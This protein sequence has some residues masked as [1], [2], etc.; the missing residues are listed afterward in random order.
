[1]S[2]T[3]PISSTYLDTGLTDVLSGA[4][5]EYNGEIYFGMSKRGY[6]VNDSFIDSYFFHIKKIN[7]SSGEISDIGFFE[8]MNYVRNTSTLLVDDNY[9]YY[10]VNYGPYTRG[11]TICR[12]DLK[13]LD[14]KRFEI[15]DNL[16]PTSTPSNTYEQIQKIDWVDNDTIVI[17][18]TFGFYFFN[19]KTE[20]W[21]KKMQL[22]N[23][24]SRSYTTVGKNTIVS[25]WGDYRNLS[26]DNQYPTIYN[27]DTETFG[28]IKLPS[29]NPQVSFYLD[30]IYYIAQTNYLHLYNEET[31]VIENS[32]SIPWTPS[33]ISYS[34]GLIFATQYKSSD[35]DILVIYD[36]NTE[37]YQKI[38]ISQ[39]MPTIN[40]AYFHSLIQPVAYK[41]SLYIPYNSLG[42][43]TVNESQKFM[44]GPKM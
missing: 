2:R 11:I 29:T 27:M 26:G 14:K 5:C 15:P 19:T 36:L 25:H 9:A 44:F 35:K 24:R 21:S 32:I 31:G 16:L 17:P 20:E 42:I 7:P 10:V 43:I 3:E 23:F 34:D 39:Q 28:F 33:S 37:D 18:H 13:T 41:H 30:G 22:T 1:V 40:T 38:M 8:E 6:I 12:V 4:A